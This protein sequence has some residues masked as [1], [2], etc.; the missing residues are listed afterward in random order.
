MIHDQNDCTPRFLV[1][2]YQLRLS[3]STPVGFLLGQVQAKD[4]D[5]S[6]DFRRIQY[7]LGENEHDPMIE[8]DPNNGSMHLIRKL[9]AGMT[10]NVTVMAIDQHNQSLHDQANVQVIS[11]D[12][13]ACLPAFTQTLYIFNTTEHRATPYDVGKKSSAVESVTSGCESASRLPLPFSFFAFREATSV[14]NSRA[15]LK[16]QKLVDASEDES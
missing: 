5:H 7:K 2:N 9:S 12:E 15:L 8:L 13:A 16:Q 14:S 6:A 4:A 3:E 10:F 11:Y 1:A